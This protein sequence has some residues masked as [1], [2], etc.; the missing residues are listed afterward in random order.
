M[1]TNMKHYANNKE[2]FGIFKSEGSRSAGAINKLFETE[3]DRQAIKRWQE[4]YDLQHGAGACEEYVKECCR[5][6][7]M[8]HENIEAQFGNLELPYDDT[9]L[10]KYK[11]LWDEYQSQF[12]NDV[13][14]IFIE[15]VVYSPKL[16]M[17]GIVDCIGYYKGKLSIIDFKFASKP[18]D[19]MY[20]TD[21]RRQVAVYALILEKEYNIKVEQLVIACGSHK[22]I[23]KP[24]I[25]IFKYNP[26]KLMVQLVTSLKSIG[27]FEMIRPGQKLYLVINNTVKGYDTYDSMI[28]SASSADEAR[29]MKP[30]DRNSTGEW[31]NDI[32]KLVV[33]EIGT[34]YTQE[35]K[36]IITSYNAG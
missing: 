35:S 15:K 11:K 14:P 29:K 3:E 1:L 7:S 30:S 28:V 8:L 9:A 4:S 36:V 22:N 34:S 17:H 27:Y 20:I 13:E 10:G 25:Q 5:R 32:T 16:K 23:N 18:K 26:K 24:E 31:E 19:E 6:G 12:L 33:T 21:Y 2:T